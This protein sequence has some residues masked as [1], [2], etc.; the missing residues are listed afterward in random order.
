M[1]F[2]YVLNV[3]VFVC[4]LQSLGL[5]DR[6]PTG[7]AT[8]SDGYAVV[9]TKQEVVV[10]KDLQRVS[11][12]SPSFEP[13]MVAINQNNRDVVIGG[14]VSYYNWFSFILLCNFGGL[15]FL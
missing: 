15:F 10:A 4:S 6:D 13:C 8:T 1:K 14:T 11:S 12:F 2:M 5:P 9:V 7:L 3:S